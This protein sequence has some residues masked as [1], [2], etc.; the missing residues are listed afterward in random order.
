[1]KLWAKNTANLIQS[2]TVHCTPWQLPAQDPLHSVKYKHAHKK[3]MLTG[4]SLK[5]NCV[6]EF[7]KCKRQTHPSSLRN[8]EQGAFEILRHGTM[9]P[10]TVRIRRPHPCFVS[11]THTLANRCMLSR[12]NKGEVLCSAPPTGC[13]DTEPD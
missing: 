3:D 4:I 11:H 6:V 10:H 1:M 12:S 13:Q 9:F 7:K 5:K 8:L 2:N